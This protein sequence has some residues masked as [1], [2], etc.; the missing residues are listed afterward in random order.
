V[1]LSYFNFSAKPFAMNP[2]P[3]FLYHSSQHTRAMTMLE[4]A[5]ES[6]ASF[7][8]L[9]GDIGCGRRRSCAI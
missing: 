9:T 5:I 4:Y 7:C 1:Y 3:A 6:Q 8:L 2:D